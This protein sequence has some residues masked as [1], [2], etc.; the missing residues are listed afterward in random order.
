LFYLKSLLS[1]LRVPSAVSDGLI[2]VVASR[3]EVETPDNFK[4]LGGNNDLTIV[5]ALVF[6]CL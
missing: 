6:Y 5:Y 2:K 1:S 3:I 4:G